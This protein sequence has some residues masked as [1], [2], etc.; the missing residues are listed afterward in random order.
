[1]SMWKNPMRSTVR[2]DIQGLRALAV[3]AVIAFHM[4]ADWLSGGY[5]V[6]SG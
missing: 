2:P 3:L 6:V 1:M 4:N 5:C